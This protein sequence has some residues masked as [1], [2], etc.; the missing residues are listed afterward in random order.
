[1]PT[2]SIQEAQDRLSDLVH[3]L[4]PGDEVVITEN[5]EPIAKL[6]HLPE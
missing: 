6:A 4:S 3:E 1:M 2:V 5:G